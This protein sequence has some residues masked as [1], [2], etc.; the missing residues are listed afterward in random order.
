M[1][2]NLRIFHAEQS[3]IILQFIL[4][5]AITYSRGQKRK[6]MLNSLIKS[7]VYLLIFR[8]NSMIC[9]GSPKSLKE[10]YFTWEL[11]PGES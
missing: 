10:S 1:F 6:K 11:R 5:I 9:K 3:I 2:S 8:Q 7:T 4:L